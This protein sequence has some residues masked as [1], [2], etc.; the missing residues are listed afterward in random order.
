MKKLSLVFTGLLA[1][2]SCFADTFDLN[3]IN[4]AMN[5]YPFH[6][7]SG[8]FWINTWEKCNG[9]DASQLL[10]LLG[11]DGKGGRTNVPPGQTAHFIYSE[12]DI[13][14]QVWGD[15]VACGEARGK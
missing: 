13:V 9:K 14:L 15:G 2:T 6:S 3:S 8:E 7:A 12:T 1:S 11:K 10:V 4:P 5:N